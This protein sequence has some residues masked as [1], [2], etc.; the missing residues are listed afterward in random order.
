M[1]ERNI[2]ADIDCQGNRAARKSKEPQQ[3]S[4]QYQK[5]GGTQRELMRIDV[6]LRRDRQKL[7]AGCVPGD[8]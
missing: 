4:R 2:L 7:A 3:T 8:R 5:L 1:L 6:D